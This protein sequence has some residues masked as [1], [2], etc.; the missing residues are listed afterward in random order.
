MYQEKGSSNEMIWDSSIVMYHGKGSSEIYDSSIF[1]V[2][3]E[4]EQ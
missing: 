1:N 2:P 4:G 3:G